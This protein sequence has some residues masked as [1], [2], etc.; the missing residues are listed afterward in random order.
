MIEGLREIE[1]INQLSLNADLIRTIK[2]FLCLIWK[3]HCRCIVTHL[4]VRKNV[5]WQVKMPEP[6]K[7]Q[8]NNIKY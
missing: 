4:E 2:R 5:G 1:I 3:R 6:R 8:S 7:N